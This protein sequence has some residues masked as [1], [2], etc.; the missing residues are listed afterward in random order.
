MSKRLPLTRSQDTQPRGPE[1]WPFIL[2]S[3]DAIPLSYTQLRHLPTDP[4]RLS[5][6]LDRLAASYP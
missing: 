5:A 1:V 3:A 2:S 4:T 6:A